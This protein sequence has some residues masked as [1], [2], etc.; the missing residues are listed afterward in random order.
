LAEVL[1][2]DGRFGAADELILASLAGTDALGALYWSRLLEVPGLLALQVGAAN[3]SVLASACSRS[4]PGGA[5]GKSRNASPA[6][7]RRKRYT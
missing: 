5:V 3:A 7:I 6:C 1:N 4:S 2:S